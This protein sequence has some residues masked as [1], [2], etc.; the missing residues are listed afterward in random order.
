MT[1]WHYVSTNPTN[2]QDSYDLW[3]DIKYG[4]KTNRISNWNPDPQR[5]K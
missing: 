3:M 5:F 1:L 2:N 4:G